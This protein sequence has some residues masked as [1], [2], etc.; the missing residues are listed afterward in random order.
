MADE[1]KIALQEV[2]EHRGVLDALKARVRAEIF[3][4]LDSQVESKPAPSNINLVINEL[5]REYLEFNK[6]RHTASVFIP[7]TGQPVHPPFDRPFLAKQ[8]MVEDNEESVKIPLIYNIIGLLQKQNED[9]SANL[10][11]NGQS[12]SVKN[13]SMQ[14]LMQS[15]PQQKFSSSVAENASSFS[16]NRK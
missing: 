8:L 15:A 3:S 2:L 9:N 16:F 14:G 10:T 13:S 7:E 5:I 12:N 4:S 11:S 6:Y 1:L